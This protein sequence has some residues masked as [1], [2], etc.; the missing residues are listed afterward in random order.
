MSGVHIYEEQTTQ[1]ILRPQT[2]GQNC[3]SFHR[4]DGT[5]LAVLWLH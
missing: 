3:F 2:W 1:N 5:L 4:Y